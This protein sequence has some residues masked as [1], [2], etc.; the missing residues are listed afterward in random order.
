MSSGSK[1][2]LWVAAALAVLLCPLLAG[3]GGRSGGVADPWS[4]HAGPKTVD[5]LS[6]KL[7]ATYSSQPW[8]AKITGITLTQKLGV[9]VV[10]VWV[11]GAGPDDQDFVQDEQI[12]KTIL[13]LDPGMA[14]IFET[15]DT[16]G[17]RVIVARQHGER[18]SSPVPAPRTPA[19]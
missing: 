13:H 9:P 17:S 11:R 2:T 3:C 7:A 10:S 12:L 6:A 19:R 8:Y 18:T 5:E 15:R 4:R 14:D 16:W 1:R